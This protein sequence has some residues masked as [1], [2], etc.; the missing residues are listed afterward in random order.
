MAIDK[1]LDQG[2]TLLE[3]I[4]CLAVLGVLAVFVMPR[5]SSSDETAQRNVVITLAGALKRGV[6]S[7]NIEWRLSSVYPNGAP[8]LFMCLKLNFLGLLH[9]RIKKFPSIIWVGR[10]KRSVSAERQ[11]VT[12]IAL[13]FG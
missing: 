1:R 12:L 5:F 2:F 8:I 10:L 4:L 7:A 6:N 11:A 9:R 3:L 13:I